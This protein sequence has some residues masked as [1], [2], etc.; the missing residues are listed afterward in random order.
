MFTYVFCYLY[1]IY[2]FWSVCIPFNLLSSVVNS[3]TTGWFSFRRQVHIQELNRQ[4][5]PQVQPNQQ[6]ENPNP[7]QVRSFCHIFFPHYSFS[8]YTVVSLHWCRGLIYSMY[9]LILLNRS[10]LWTHFQ[11]YACIATT[12]VLLVCVFRLMNL[13]SDRLLLQWRD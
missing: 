8:Q 1:T 11:F 9:Y 5:P 12:I 7:N 3:H 2:F 13:M 4:Q 6:N 10:S